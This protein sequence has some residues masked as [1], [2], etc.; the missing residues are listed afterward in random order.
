V[1]E[2]AYTGE[3]REQPES[4]ALSKVLETSNV[5]PLMV[6][7]SMYY[8]AVSDTSIKNN[9]F[10]AE[11][12]KSGIEHYAQRNDALALALI[13]GAETVKRLKSPV[14]WYYQSRY[15]FIQSLPPFLQYDY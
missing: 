5:A 14:Q 11:L 3:I 6:I 15:L 9:R 4:Q 8:L 13:I 10:K 2:P 1:L 7:T 12:L